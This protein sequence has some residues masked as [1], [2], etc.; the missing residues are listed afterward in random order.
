MIPPSVLLASE[1]PRRRELLGRLGIDFKVETAPVEELTAAADPRSVP[2]LNAAAKAAAVAERHPA[3][4]V[5]GA[6]TV[7]CLN[8]R[9]IGKPRDRADAEE[10]LHRLSGTS[11]EV[12]TGL[13]LLSP[14]RK[15]REVW[16]E[17]ATVRFRPL[18]AAAIDDYLARVYVLDK[19]GAYAIQEH[20]DELVEQL[21]G[22][23]ENVIGLPLE[24]LSRRLAA[25][26]PGDGGVTS[27]R[28]R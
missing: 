23:F 16:E 14:A 2:L 22:E 12:I 7:I 13:A 4:V 20:G 18:T 21:E 17:V 6:D 25:L 26:L 3:A 27:A 28:R 1:S 24:R 8:G 11:H 19:A 5:I 9:I 10:I 15:I